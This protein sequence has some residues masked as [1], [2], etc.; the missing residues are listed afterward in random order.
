MESWR[1]LVYPA[2]RRIRRHP[3]HSGAIVLCLALGLGA[4]AALFSVFDTLLLRPLPLRE[5]HRLAFV[6]DMRE[7]TDPFQ[8]AYVDY[9]ELGRHPAFESVG[10]ARPN[11]F[12]GTAEGRPQRWS[13][14]RVTADY[15]PTLGIEPILGRSITPEDARPGA[16]P[17]ALLSHGLWQRRFD[18][19]T[20][21]LGR[22]MILD[23]NPYVLVGVLPPGF[24]LPMETDLWVPLTVDLDGLSPARLTMPSNLVVA[25][26]APG[27]TFE[28][29][30]ERAATLARRIARE[31]PEQ[32]TGWGLLLIPLRWQILDDLGGELR[33]ALM[34]LLGVVGFLLLIACANVAGL[35]AVRS[36]ERDRELAVQR[37]LGA[38]RRDLLVPMFVESLLLALSGGALAWGLARVAL[39]FWNTLSPVEA[40]AL[41]S[42]FAGASM[43]GRV[44]AFTFGLALLTALVC[45]VFPAWILSSVN[46]ARALQGRERAGLSR[47]RRRS[48]AA[49]VVGELAVAVM[50]LLGAALTLESLGRLLEMDTGFDAEHK[51]I[52]ELAVPRDRFESH[53][54]R[55]VHVERCLRRV[56]RLPGVRGAEATT[57]VPLSSS[58][59]DQF[60]T[61][62]GSPPADAAEVPVTAHRLVTPGYL[63]LMDVEV[64]EG[65]A[66]TPEDRRDGRPVVVVSRELARRAWPGQSPLGRQLQ[67]GSSPDEDA[68]V[69]TVVGMVEDVQ[70][71]RFNFGTPRPVWYLPYAQHPTGFPRITLVV[72]TV[73]E[74]IAAFGE[75]RQA[76]WEIA[77]EQPVPDPR[78]LEQH[79][80]SFLGPRRFRVVLM[81]AMAGLG[82]LLAAVGLYGMLSYVVSRERRSTAIRLALGAH[83]RML[84]RRIFGRGLR[85][86]GWG[87]A[88]GGLGGWILTRALAGWVEQ[89]GSLDLGIFLWAAGVLAGVGALAV[90]FPAR[91]TTEVDPA[92]ILRAS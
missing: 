6:L 38:R 65:R 86:V 68:P 21:I 14:A 45:S 39:R 66:L 2:L 10:L 30:N 53:A 44:V 33:P 37:A 57:N 41:R 56:R 77:P 23:G 36:M 32:R 17:V 84:R 11:S 90:Y 43:D 69:L 72:E 85:L 58:S 55:V 51:L 12:V 73:G 22:E 63:S 79:V 15:L 74:P 89:I 46:G 31:Y 61:V 7:G 20:S 25:R 18:G 48:L 82:L 75:I 13:G 80:T 71:D 50:L 29:A 67:I 52:L 87:L 28:Q 42:H 9:L 81:S 35:L 83:P 8:A 49:L 34:L 54:Q 19:E 26:L 88:L 64:I 59:W 5:G 16:T 78:T 1:H 60:Y 3:L 76:I 24:D 62:V 70:E 91:R 40:S 4:N 27:T 92:W 47:G